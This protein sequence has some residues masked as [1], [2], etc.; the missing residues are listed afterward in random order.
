MTKQSY[1]GST[2]QGSRL[3]CGDNLDML[4]KYVASE[5][6]DL[7]Y[8]DPPFN[9][10]Q[11]YNVWARDPRSNERTA[12]EEAFKD[13]WTWAEASESYFKTVERGGPVSVALEAFRKL[14]GEKPM[15]AYLAMMAPRLV[16]LRRVL[17]PTGSLYLHCD[18]TASHYL[19]LLL[20]AVLGPS[21]FRN[22]IIWKRTNAHN[23]A[24]RY[25][26][27]HDVI[28]FYAAGPGYGW[29]DPR[30]AHDEDYV[31]H[32]FT[33]VDNDGRRF[34]AVDLTGPG[35]RKGESGRPWRGVN[36]TEVGRH[37]AV[38][39]G[40][41]ARLAIKGGTVQDRLDALDANGRIYWPVKTGG[42]PGLKWYANELAGMAIPDVWTDIPRLT[43]QS[44]ERLGYAT[45][46]PRALLERIIVASSC[47]GDMILDP[48]CGCGTTIE[49]AEMLGRRW[50]GI[51]ISWKA[52]NVI[53][54]QRPVMQKAEY[55]NVDWPT[56]IGSARAL[57]ARDP[58]RFQWWALTVIGVELWKE[59]QKRG[60]DRGVD[61]RLS[62]RDGDKVGQAVV[63]VKG[64]A[65]P[66]STVRDL[67]GVMA[68]EEADF[69]VVVSLK[70][71]TTGMRNEAASAGF[72]ES[73]GERYSR[74]QLLTVAE[75]L[76]GVRPHV[77]RTT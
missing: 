45:Q 41:T 31:E 6:I 47:E 70:P 69:G 18:P 35:T 30:I 44:T 15:L 34:Q 20:D 13:T 19:K 24:R 51:D 23:N 54:Q 63:S 67:R 16:E 60:A 10:K 74:M 50:I 38:P 55:E 14:L 1:H 43:A 77:P 21:N 57:F 53:E 7:V 33:R 49:A 46:K 2:H 65:I 62:F 52:I 29:Y 42:K 12:Q 27:V 66:A 11:M 48:F 71:F 64:G 72:Y 5:S 61:G 26:P 39:G 56:D 3:I 40:V 28:L 58:Y 73:A 76:D 25:G 17:K 32:T 68:R 22:E 4:Q 75:L 9:S 37:W 36:P 8:L 59:L